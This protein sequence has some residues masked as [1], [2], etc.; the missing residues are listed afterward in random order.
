MR[1]WL[2]FW[3]LHDTSTINLH[4]NQGSSTHTAVYRT[5]TLKA[6]GPVRHNV[7][8]YYTTRTRHTIPYHGCYIAW[9]EWVTT[10]PKYVQV[11]SFVLY[12]R[13]ASFLHSGKNTI[14]AVKNKSHHNIV[15]RSSETSFCLTCATLMS[16]CMHMACLP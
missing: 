2:C 3:R 9:A 1:W 10:A 12:K 6:T 8:S 13:I 15:S 4:V 7:S 11:G 14:L 5:A 16:V